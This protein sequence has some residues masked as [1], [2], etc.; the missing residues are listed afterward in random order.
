M[1]SR[2][3]VKKFKEVL[4]GLL[5]SEGKCM[6]FLR[7]VRNHSPSD[8]SH[9]KVQNAQHSISTYFSNKSHSATI[10]GLEKI[11]KP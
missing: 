3:R 10:K 11:I 2:S 8:T 5:D 6:M 9:P 7:K 1:L 4:L